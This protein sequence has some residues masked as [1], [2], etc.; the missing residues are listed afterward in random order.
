MTPVCLTC[1]EP[2]H[3]IDI[4]KKSHYN[5]TTVYGLCIIHKKPYEFGRQMNNDNGCRENPFS[6]MKKHSNLTDLT[7]QSLRDAIIGGQ[8]KP[9]ERLLQ[10]NLANQMGVSQRTIREALAKLEAKGLIVHEPYKG[11]RV[12]ALPLEE[13]R[14]IYFL[15]SILESHAIDLAHTRM[16]EEDFA[17]MERCCRSLLLAQIQTAPLLPRKQ[18]DSFTGSCCVIQNRIF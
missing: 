8:I 12:T 6:G 5:K 4:S 9:G 2:I 1:I 13:I 18:I 17:E 7:Y 15:R 11:A 3:K 14:E 10:I 16:T